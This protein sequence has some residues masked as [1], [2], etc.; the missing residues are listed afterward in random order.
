MI[1][2][3]APIF[4]E[5]LIMDLGNSRLVRCPTEGLSLVQAV[6]QASEMIQSL[7]GWKVLALAGEQEHPLCY[8]GWPC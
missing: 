1:H 3:G 2:S 5:Y 4:R 6:R 7:A 8:F